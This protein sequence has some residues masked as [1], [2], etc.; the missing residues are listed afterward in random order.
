MA[1]PKYCSGVPTLFHCQVIGKNLKCLVF[2]AFSLI[3]IYREFL[4][5]YQLGKFWTLRYEGQLILMRSALFQLLLILTCTPYVAYFSL[6][7]FWILG[8]EFGNQSDLICSFR[9]EY[10]IILD[11]RWCHMPNKYV[12]KILRFCSWKQ[13]AKSVTSFTIYHAAK[14]LKTQYRV[15]YSDKTNIFIS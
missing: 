9:V 15:L 11:G 10:L 5:Q 12:H 3:S 4:N 6:K 8:L 7:Y 1:E 2:L 13:I 14:K